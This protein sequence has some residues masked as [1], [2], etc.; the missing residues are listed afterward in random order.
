M[1][2]NE[3][4]VSN[5]GA[6]RDEA[7]NE[8]EKYADYQGLDRKER[9]HIR[10]LA[11]EMLGMVETIAGNFYAYY[12][13]EDDSDGYQLHLEAKVEMSTAKKDAL[14]DAS[15]SKQNSSAKGIMGKLRDVFQY[16]RMGYIEAMSDPVYMNNFDK[17][18]YG[19]ISFDLRSGANVWSLSQYQTTVKENDS[20]LEDWDEL[21]KSII[22][23]L[24]DD[25]TVGIKGNN[26]EMIITKKR[27]KC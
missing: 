9:M 4:Y 27:K 21:E 26:V 11:E 19:L 5:Q 2:T 8:T 23:N 18:G 17:M 6:G 20:E 10:I 25:V 12:W 1:K 7:L 13:I 15:T 3:I 14:I 24:A 22:A 16:F